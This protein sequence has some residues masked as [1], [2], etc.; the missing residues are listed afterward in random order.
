MGG[1]LSAGYIVKLSRDGHFRLGAMASFGALTTK[2]DPYVWGNPI[3]G[4]AD[5]KYY[6]DYKGTASKFKKRNRVFTW[7]GPTNLGVQLTYDLIYR[8]REKGGQL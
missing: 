3:T 1:G 5:G 7:M 4:E 6:Y 8:K 2:Y